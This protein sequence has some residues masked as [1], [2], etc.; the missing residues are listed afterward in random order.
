MHHLPQRIEL[1]INNDSVVFGTVLS[2][3]FVFVIGQIIQK[4]LLEPIKEYKK[5]IGKIDNELKYHANII[6]SSGLDLELVIESS[7][8]MRRLSGEFEALYK[9]IPFRKP[10]SYVKLIPDHNNAAEAA[11]SIIRISN[12]GGQSGREG[13]N[14]DEVIKI[15]K[16]LNIEELRP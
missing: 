9:Q 4:F 3:V 8:T 2:G 10:L 13:M 7:R 6:V 14:Y 5:V 12:A 16:L 15:R 1:V 11:S